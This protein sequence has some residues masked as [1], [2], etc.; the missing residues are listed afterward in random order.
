MTDTTRIRN[1]AVAWFVRLRDENA[2]EAQWLAFLDWIEAD[3][4]HRRAYDA[5]E[6]T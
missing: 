5:V 3:P 6:R 1:D 4:E 2:S